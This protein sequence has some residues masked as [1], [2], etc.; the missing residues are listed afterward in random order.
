MYTQW[1]KITERDLVQKGASYN[2]VKSVLTLDKLVL[3]MTLPNIGSFIP[4]DQTFSSKTASKSTKQNQESSKKIN[5]TNNEVLNLYAM[6]L[7]AIISGQR[8]ILTKARKSIANWKIRKDQVLGCKVTLRGKPALAFLD[9]TIR[10]QNLHEHDMFAMSE[11]TGDSK[12]NSSNSLKLQSLGNLSIGV[13]KVNLYPELEDLW[14]AQNLGSKSLG[15]DLS[16]SFKTTKELSYI[17]NYIMRKP[18]GK[19]LVEDYSKNIQSFPVHI[20]TNR[21]VL[22]LKNIISLRKLYLTALG[23]SVG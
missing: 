11:V 2:R 1:T 20:K 12:Q 15:L 14:I 6:S 13:K 17:I 9:K 23:L 10:F 8:P 4:Q 22:A 5:S 21:S 7:L 18:G 3:N 16:L 19:K